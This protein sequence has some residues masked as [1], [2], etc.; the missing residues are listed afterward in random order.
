M[1]HWSHPYINDDLDQKDFF[2]LKLV[3]FVGSFY[4]VVQFNTQSLL[5]FLRYTLRLR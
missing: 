1:K 3:R 2:A 5:G 4:S